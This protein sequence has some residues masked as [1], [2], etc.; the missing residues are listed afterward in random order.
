MPDSKQFLEVASGASG[1][2]RTLAS[3]PT[4]ADNAII[5]VESGTVRWSETTGSW[6]SATAGVGLLLSGA[7]QPF[8]IGAG[9]PLSAFAFVPV[10][11]AAQIQVA[12]YGYHGLGQYL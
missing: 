4:T 2:L 11:G 3:A 5:R 9:V 10:G 6:L 12:Y 1:I 8:R 7:D